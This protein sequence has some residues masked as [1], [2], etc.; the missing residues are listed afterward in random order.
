MRPEM[1]FMAAGAVALVGGTAKRKRLPS[2][3]LTAVIATIALVII[4]SMTADTKA[5]PLV[6][7]IGFLFLMA[8][9]MS[10][11]PALTAKKGSVK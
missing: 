4:A 5:A 6:R 3:S 10:A 9:V 2:N 7:A 8:A 1:P 11:V